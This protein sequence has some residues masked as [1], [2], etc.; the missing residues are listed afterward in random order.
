M[1]ARVEIPP[2]KFDPDKLRL[3]VRVGVFV[4]LVLVGRIVSRI[5]A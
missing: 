4:V 1:N 3:L 2:A 5:R